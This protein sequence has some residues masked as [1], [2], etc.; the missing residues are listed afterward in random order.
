MWKYGYLNLERLLNYDRLMISD[1][2][3]IQAHE[4]TG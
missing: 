4:S 3:C 2:S 1:Y